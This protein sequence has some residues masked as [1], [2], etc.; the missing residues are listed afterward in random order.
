MTF[1]SH[2]DYFKS[3]PATSLPLLVAIAQTV[4]NLLPDS[5]RCVSYNTPAFKNKRVFFYYAAFKKHIGVF[6]PSH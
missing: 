5:S 6:L 3:V 4:E 2:E 1:V